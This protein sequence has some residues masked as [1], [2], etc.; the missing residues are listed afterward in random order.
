MDR[1]GSNCMAEKEAK[2]QEDEERKKER[3]KK[4]SNR[5][6]LKDSSILGAFI[7]FI[8]IFRVWESGFQR[9]IKLKAPFLCVWFVCELQTVPYRYC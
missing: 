5:K 7:I 9:E 1:I 6:A 2:A 4:S 8:N 3:Q